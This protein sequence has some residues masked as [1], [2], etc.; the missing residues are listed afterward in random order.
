MILAKDVDFSKLDVTGT[1][2]PGCKPYI[3]TFD[4]IDTGWKI[5]RWFKIDLD[6][7]R[8]WY[9]DLE[10]N[11]A[12]C[13]F[14]YKD[15]GYM[16]TFDPSDPNAE[17]GHK[18]MPDT[19]WYTLCWNPADVE[20]PLPPERSNAKP[21]FKEHDETDDLNPRY[22][23]TGYGLD[24]CK[25]IQEYVRVKKVL[26]SIMTPGTILREHQDSPDKLRFHIS[27]YNNEDAYWTIEGER[28]QVPDDGWVYLVN[29]SLVHELHNN[30]QTP[31]INMYGKIF[32]EDIIK[33][34]I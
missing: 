21:E 33:L 23:F 26:I 1:Q 13:K 4:K 27:I 12:D 29:T 9:H 19:A 14:T 10:K 24:I 32:T 28:I 3:R 6:R 2:I 18:F 22:C 17:T 25:Q 34:G 8:S 20:G 7:L 30:G 11:H 15:H 16:W 31:R 5:K